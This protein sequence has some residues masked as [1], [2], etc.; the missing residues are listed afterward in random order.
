MAVD[1]DARALDDIRDCL[2]EGK[3]DVT[4]APSGAEALRV[5]EFSKV[6]LVVLD[7][8][9]PDVDGLSLLQYIREHFKDIEVIMTAEFPTVPDAVLAI[10]RG[11]ENL[12]VK[13]LQPDELRSTVNRLIGKLSHRRALVFECT[14]PETY[15]LIGISDG[16]CNVIERIERA[17]AINANVLIHGES[18]TGK[19]LVARAIHYGGD[20]AAAR[21]VPVN[22]TAIP[23]TLI[24]SELFGHVKGAFTGAKDSRA[25]FFQIADGGTIFLDEIGDASLNLQGKL[26]RVLQNKEIHIVGSSHVRKVDTR[27]IAATHKDLL[28]MVD[29]NLFREDL[30]YRLDVVDIYVPPLRERPADI[31][32]LVNHFLN[33]YAKEMGIEPPIFTD[34]AIENLKNHSWPGN[35]RELENLAQRLLVN[36]DSDTLDVADLPKTM[37]QGVR[38]RAEGLQTLSALEAEHILR[39]LESTGG[40]KTRAAAILGIDRKTLR[41]KLKRIVEIHQPG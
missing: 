4:T 8:Q 17:A 15:G 18:G 2:A 39:V 32:P 24:E 3:L 20:R 31:L 26:L 22:C 34:R 41:E 16:I 40:N 36:A 23:D 19:E 7:L 13:P 33:Q 37:R 30:Y 14:P 5:L 9:I 6:D 28:A 1:S 21:F 29:K 35:V 10:K 25:G 12:L 38:P 27:I 11:A